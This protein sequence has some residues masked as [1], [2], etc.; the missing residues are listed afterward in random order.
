M[1]I[2]LLISLYYAFVGIIHIKFNFISFLRD[3]LKSSGY[4]VTLEKVSI[5][6]V[7]INVEGRQIPRDDLISLQNLYGL[8]PSAM[9]NFLNVALY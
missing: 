9:N 4:T 2:I 8:A 1:I 6:S 5:M 3:Y 7:H